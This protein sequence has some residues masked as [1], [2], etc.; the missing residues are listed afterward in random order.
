MGLKYY[1]SSP[2]DLFLTKNLSRCFC[3]LFLY[4][5]TNIIVGIGEH[6]LIVHR[7]KLVY[8]TEAL[9]NLQLTSSRKQLVTRRLYKM[10]WFFSSRSIYVAKKR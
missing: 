7:E 2:K 6:S 1:Y 9:Q 10:C 3:F 8:N 4:V 5:S